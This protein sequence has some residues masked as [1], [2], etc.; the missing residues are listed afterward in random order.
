MSAINWDEIRNRVQA[1]QSR[2][3]LSF[4][5]SAEVRDRVLRERARA[6]A[7]E[8]RT[9]SEEMAVEHV[10]FTLS[11]EHYAIDAGQAKEVFPL[12][13]LMPVP[14]TP[15]FMAGIINLRGEMC[16]V[17]DLRKFF[18]LPQ[19]GLTNAVSAVIVRDGDRTL[20]ILADVV[21]GMLNIK[22][23]ELQ[24]APEMFR[25]AQRRYLRGI[26]PDGTAVLDAQSIINDPSLLIEEYPD[27]R[28][29][30]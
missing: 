24:P 30:T 18:G 12:R 6:A 7:R 14:C 17:I 16:T 9:E 29:V 2:L 22:P 4:T 11:R 3:D 28:T 20:G 1:T 26:S 23:S 27:Q 21:T 19:Q 15:E 13:D 10:A 25:G 8:L 5:P